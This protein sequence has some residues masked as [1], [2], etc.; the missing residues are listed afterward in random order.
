[1]AIGCGIRNRHGHQ[2]S[3]GSSPTDE[4]RLVAS[5]TV[6]RRRTR[7]TA[8]AATTELAMTGRVN[9]VNENEPPRAVSA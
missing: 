5:A 8:A 4:E 3:G 2:T 7:T 9:W 1:M 6:S